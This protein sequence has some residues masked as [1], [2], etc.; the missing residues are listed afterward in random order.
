MLKRYVFSLLH[1]L[2]GLLRP[3]RGNAGNSLI[4]FK[5]DGIG[6]FLLATGAIK[7]IIDNTE[8]PIVLLVDSKVAA[9]ARKQFPTI[10]VFGAEGAGK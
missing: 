5:P 2:A 8:N 9:L 10:E 1:R 4:I 3:G 7:K 6:D